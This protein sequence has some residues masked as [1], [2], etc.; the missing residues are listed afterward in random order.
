MV[1]FGHNDGLVVFDELALVAPEEAGAAAYSLASGQSKARSKADGSLR[2]RTEWRV[3]I[4]STG[5]IGLADHIRASRKGDRPMAG[6]ELRLLDLAADAGQQMGVWAVLHGADGPAA[7]SDAI[8]MASGRD[9]GHAGPAFL[10]AYCGR[11]DEAAALAKDLVAAFLKEVVRPGDTGQAYRGALRFAAIAAAGELATMFGITGWEPGAAGASAQRLYHR[12]AAMFGR[13]RSRE[14]SDVLRRLKGV[15]ETE[16]ASFAPLGEDDTLPEAEPSAGGRDGEARSL[17][18]YGW[19]RVRGSE[20]SYLITGSGWAA[21]FQGHNAA[22]AARVIDEAGFLDRDAD[23]KRFQK[24]ISVRGEK[25]WLYCVR[26][27]LT[28]ADFGD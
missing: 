25:H 14:A 20:V 18:T 1:A 17:R 22:E 23:G 12:W 11:R 21:I 24:K 2:R 15:I 10:D 3:A 26:G 8:K 13:D 28:E 9:Y 6:Q 27:A 19:R 4:L 7:L 5:E 16:R